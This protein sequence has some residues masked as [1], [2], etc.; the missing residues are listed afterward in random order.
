MTHAD[1][2]RIRKEAYTL[3]DNLVAAYQEACQ[4]FGYDCD[5]QDILTPLEFWVHRNY[6]PTDPQ[7][8]TEWEK[9]EQKHER[10][11]DRALAKAEAA[12]N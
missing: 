7:E 4:Y 6:W 9:E 11:I 2:P 12:L 10:L 8:A 5:V 1:E 3:V